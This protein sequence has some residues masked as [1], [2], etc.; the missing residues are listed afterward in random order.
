[1]CNIYVTRP[2]GPQRKILLRLRFSSFRLSSLTLPQL[3]LFH[4]CC[5]TSQALLV[6]GKKGFR[7]HLLKFRLIHTI[8][9]SRITLGMFLAH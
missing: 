6:Y 3:L 5:S 7:H 4:T 1:M 2:P 9:F 8:I